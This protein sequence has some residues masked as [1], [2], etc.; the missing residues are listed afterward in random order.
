MKDRDEQALVKARQARE[1]VVGGDL[2]KQQQIEE[3]TP[4]RVA[5]A[6]TENNLMMKVWANQEQQ[7]MVQ[8]L[9]M[10]LRDLQ[11]LSA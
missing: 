2:H 8:F 1:G 9:E 3:G 11:H 6:R 4:S 7:K 5:E 10:G